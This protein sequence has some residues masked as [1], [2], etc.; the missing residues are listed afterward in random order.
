MKEISQTYLQYEKK[1]FDG[2][3]ELSFFGLYPKTVTRNFSKYAGDQLPKTT[4]HPMGKE[5]TNES[6]N[7]RKIILWRNIPSFELS[8]IALYP[9]VD[10]YMVKW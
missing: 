4:G 2:N 5:I 7:S 3:A 9:G 10:S 1:Y 6:S 8:F